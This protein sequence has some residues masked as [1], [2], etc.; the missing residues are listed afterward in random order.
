MDYTKSRIADLIHNKLT[1]LSGVLDL[2]PDIN[3]NLRPKSIEVTRVDK[4]NTQVRVKEDS[5]W[6]RRFM[7]KVS[8]PI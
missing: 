8:E 4:L 7:I 6:P 5:K 2:D 1:E 3:G